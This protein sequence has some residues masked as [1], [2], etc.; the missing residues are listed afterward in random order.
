MRKKICLEVTS[1]PNTIGKPLFWVSA[2]RPALG[3][4]VDSVSDNVGVSQTVN[5]YPTFCELLSL[6]RE[7]VKDL[8]G[9]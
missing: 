6:A 8:R 9:C 7:A 1:L 5:S 3:R 4:K 2:W